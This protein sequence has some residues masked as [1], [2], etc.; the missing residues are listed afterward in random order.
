MTSRRRW[1]TL[2]RSVLQRA[3]GPI[4]SRVFRPVQPP[5]HSTGQL[6]AQ[7]AAEFLA[8]RI[9]YERSLSVPYNQRDMR[10]D[11]MRD[12]LGRLGNPQNRLRIVHVAGTKG[13]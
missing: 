10:L 4:S 12:L 7:A 3:S 2:Q 11:R 9:D 8:S 13:K 1:S 6:S 5:M